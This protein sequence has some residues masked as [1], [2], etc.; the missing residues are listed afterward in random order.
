MSDKLN[1]KNVRLIKAME[2]GNN[3]TDA[4]KIVG[5]NRDYA[6]TLLKQPKMIKALN[7]AGLTDEYIADG[8]KENIT[9]GMGKDAKASD[10]LRGLEIA[11][12]LKGYTD[13]TPTT[14]TTQTNVFIN[15]LN[16][17]QD[18]DL[19]AKVDTLTEELQ[20]IRG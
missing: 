10:S 4:S 19:L 15:E 6:T 11:T 14:P 17:M 8:L 2:K 18:V 7:K 1:K 12:K 13:S 3:I 5:Y 16:T 9:A 20:E